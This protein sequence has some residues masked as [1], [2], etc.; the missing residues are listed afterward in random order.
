MTIFT[1]FQLKR[2]F[3]FG[4][5]LFQDQICRPGIRTV[6][7]NPYAGRMSDTP[8]LRFQKYLSKNEVSTVNVYQK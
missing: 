4:E 7:Q 5:H 2:F 6:P 1:K 3:S 8:G